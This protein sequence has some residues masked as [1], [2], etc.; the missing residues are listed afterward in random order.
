[1]SFRFNEIKGCVSRLVRINL[2]RGLRRLTVTYSYPCLYV[3]THLG[4][5]KG[6]RERWL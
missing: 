2:G 1:M 6:S 3:K 4:F 5:P